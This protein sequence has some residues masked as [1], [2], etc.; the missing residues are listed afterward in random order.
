MCVLVGNSSLRGGLQ[1]GVHT[2]ERHQLSMGPRLDNCAL[3]SDDDEVAVLNCGEPVSNGKGS[4]ALT[5]FF[6]GLLHDPLALGVQSTCCLIQQE[7]RWV[8]N[9]GP[10]N[11]HTLLLTT[12]E[13]RPSGA[14]LSLPTLVGFLVQEFEVAHLLKLEQALLRDC[15]A[16]VLV[17]AV[18]DIRLDCGVEQD[19]FLADEADLPP[20]PSNVDLLEGDSSS[21]NGD[22]ATRRVVE[23]LQERHDRA[24]AATRRA[25]QTDC[26]PRFH[27]E[28]DALQHHRVRPEGVGKFDILKLDVSSFCFTGRLQSES[29]LLPFGIEPVH[30]RNPIQQLKDGVAGLSGLGGVS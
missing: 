15:L 10:A 12:R 16:G 11:R 27:L 22:S 25:H 3:S 2:V 28:G 17:E 7:N 30:L 21:T 6:Q 19:G 23:S 14:H 5:S 1:F 29:W 9:Q 18:Q 24:L 13:P 8:S 20:P 26:L 4:T